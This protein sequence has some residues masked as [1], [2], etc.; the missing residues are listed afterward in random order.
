APAVEPA[1]VAGSASKPVPAKPSARVAARHVAQ[2]KEVTET[3]A[4]TAKKKIEPLK[5]HAASEP[6]DSKH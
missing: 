4:T 1:P 3:S 6:K 2:A 5:H